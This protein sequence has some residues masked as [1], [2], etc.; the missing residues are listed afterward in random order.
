MQ[1]SFMSELPLKANE[2]KMQGLGFFEAFKKLKKEYEANL[3]FKEKA[4][5]FL[6]LLIFVVSLIFGVLSYYI[7]LQV[8]AKMYV[9]TNLNYYSVIFAFVCFSLLFLG[10]LYVIRE[11]IYEYF[12]FNA[13]L[14]RVYEQSVFKF[15]FRYIFLCFFAFLVLNA[16]LIGI[17][18]YD[19][20]LEQNLPFGY[21]F[22]IA[23]M[24]IFD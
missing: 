18:A 10:T 1:K 20:A 8:E 16:V 2:F 14:L 12:S 9:Y 4:L 3:G 11:R 24:E 15:Y 5:S 19:Y 6:S 13:V 22:S 23:L 17:L 21:S 7:F